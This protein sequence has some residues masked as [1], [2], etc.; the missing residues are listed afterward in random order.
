MM[1]TIRFRSLALA[2]LVALAAAPGTASA[3]FVA[4]YG[5]QNPLGGF[6]FQNPYFSYSR[7]AYQSLNFTA[8][9]GATISANRWYSGSTA[10]YYG[11]YNRPAYAATYNKTIPSSSY[12]SSV[13]PPFKAPGV[14]QAMIGNGQAMLDRNLAAMDSRKQVFDQWAY[15]KLGVQ[16]LKDPALITGPIELRKALAPESQADTASGEAINTIL[17][18]SLALERSGAKAAG[19]SLPPELL[20]QIRFGGSPAG[21]ALN[22]LRFPQQLPF[23]SLF[24]QDRMR[25]LKEEIERDFA[26]VAESTSTSKAVDQNRVARL[27]DVVQRTR[28]RV[29]PVARDLPFEDATAARRFLNDLDGVAKVL[30]EGGNAGLVNSRWASEG[31]TV[32]DLVKHMV[33]YRLLF[34]PAPRDGAEAYAALHRGLAAYHAALNQPQ[35]VKK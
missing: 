26:L 20:A 6:P 32:P 14:T 12:S 23:P 31:T 11:F 8:V 3:Q 25:L 5:L 22:L 34:G 16:G 27:V 28:D 1:H 15:E 35:P 29:A 7:H 18:A 10:G 24:N 4:G 19:V 17:V 13:A 33:K 9:N 21:E 2:G 30:R